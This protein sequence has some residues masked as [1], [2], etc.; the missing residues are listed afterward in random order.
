MRKIFT[1]GSAA[2]VLSVAPRTVAKWCDSG[3]LKC[4]RIPQSGDRRIMREHLIEF[5]KLNGLP[6][7]DLEDNNPVASE[8]AQ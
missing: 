3:K 6:T 4:Y 1:T 5:C 2:K 7:D 8:K